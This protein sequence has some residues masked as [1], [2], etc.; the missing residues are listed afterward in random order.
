MYLWLF[1]TSNNHFKSNK[2]CVFFSLLP[3][4]LIIAS[5]FFAGTFSWC[6]RHRKMQVVSIWRTFGATQHDKISW[7]ICRI[8]LSSQKFKCHCH[9]LSHF[10]VFCKTNKLIHTAESSPKSKILHSCTHSACPHRM[11]NAVHLITRLWYCGD[12]WFPTLITSLPT[13][14]LSGKD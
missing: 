11:P 5:D 1:F 6:W 7:G 2:H 14:H 3:A 10:S 9:I 8:W 12:K 4:F 13:H